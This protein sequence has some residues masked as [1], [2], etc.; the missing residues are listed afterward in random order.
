VPIEKNVAAT[1]SSHRRLLIVIAALGAAAAAVAV[2]M[3]LR[4]PDSSASPGTPL[5]PVRSVPSAPKAPSSPARPAG[6]QPARRNQPTRRAEAV[7]PNGLP[8]VVA[9]ALRRHRVVVVS[10]YASDAALDTLARIESRA[11]AA[12]ARAGFVAVNVL[13]RKRSEPLALA[14]GVVEAPGTLV[15]RRPGKLVTHIEG[16]ADR[17][18]VAQAAANAGS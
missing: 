1:L 4:S 3:L 10:L 12:D 16:F 2:F 17:V 8:S 14:T 13:D 11:G 15:F 7:A 6:A 5:T 9:R 18:A